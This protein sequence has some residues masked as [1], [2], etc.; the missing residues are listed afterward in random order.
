MKSANKRRVRTVWISDVHLG[1]RGSQADL[2]LDFL[3]AID[4]DLLYLVG[5]IIDMW[6]MK[7]KPYWPQ[8][9]NNV[10]RKILGKAK[11]G[12]RVIYIPG[13]HDS[14]LHG[15]RDSVFG[16]ISIK[17]RVVHTTA[18]GQRL[19]VLH[20]DQF[21]AAV[22]TSRWLGAAG[23]MAYE[24]LLTLNV[25]I[26]AVRRLFGAPHWSLAR[27]LK[28]KVK[29]V[30]RAIGNFEKALAMAAMKARVDGVICG[31]IHRP[32]IR[33]FGETV[34]YNCGD[35]VESCTALI[36]LHNGAIELWH[37]Q[38]KERVPVKLKAV[39]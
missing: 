31:H 13:N 18:A 20:G 5:D 10:I 22:T 9:H 21:D 23:G 37:W 4:C 26:N 39:A 6:R 7:Q 35:W 11:H 30:V 8:Q 1:F 24:Y 29:N 16:N 28:Y 15:Y 27:Y 2:L 34:Y 3:H 17:E 36:E 33:T 19:L 38:D 12:T 14:L 32:E 25:V